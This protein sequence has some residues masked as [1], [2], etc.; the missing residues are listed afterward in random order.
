M[1]EVTG[2]PKLIEDAGRASDD[3]RATRA[4]AREDAIRAIRSMERALVE[5]LAGE[6]LKGLREVVPGYYAARVRSAGRVGVAAPYEPLPE[7]RP[8]DGSGRE[9]LVVNAHGCLEMARS[10]RAFGR[11]VAL[12][13][14]ATDDDLLVEDVENLARLYAELLGE[15]VERARRSAE[16]FGRLNAIAQ[17]ISAA[18]LVA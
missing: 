15:H 2:L 13:R 7:P 6:T 16:R 18:L 8:G 12:S 4:R 10:T 17:R 9:V 3:L 14:D 1:T 11:G 5:A